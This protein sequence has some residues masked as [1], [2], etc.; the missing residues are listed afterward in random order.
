MTLLSSTMYSVTSSTLRNRSPSLSSF[1]LH[2]ASCVAGPGPHPSD[3][4]RS[5]CRQAAPKM[6]AIPVG[7]DLHKRVRVPALVDEPADKRLQLRLG[8]SIG[9]DR[10]RACER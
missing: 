5:W 6:E 2:L 1:I 4:H 8:L 3:D 10:H 7:L 9:A